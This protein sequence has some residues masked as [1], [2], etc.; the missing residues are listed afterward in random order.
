MA[1][2]STLDRRDGRRDDEPRPLQ[3]TLDFVKYPEGSVLA[4]AGDTVV[5][6]NVTVEGRVPP[7]LRDTGEGWLTSEYAM[8]PRATEERSPREST[9]GSIS[10]RSA[11]IQRLIGRS[12]R[13]SLDMGS[14]GERT[15]VVDCDVLQ[16]DGGTRT[17]AITG[18]FVAVVL[19]LLHLKEQKALPA[20]PVRDQLAAVSVG[21]VAG[22]PL[23]DLAYD[24]DSR[25]GVDLN[26]IATAR[27]GIVEVQG[28][29]EREPFSRRDLDR[30][31][32]LAETGLER[33]FAAQRSVLDHRLEKAGLKSL[34]A[35][36]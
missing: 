21:I 9:R 23:L 24:E 35:E 33:A 16:A 7:F 26:L 12:L 20:W 32:D 18:A 27:K 25:A 19:A 1:N 10:G 17:T 2:S 14:L 5:V 15:L 34:V 3:L 8:L 28:T 36:K 13:A 11:E 29:A 30:L 6:C 31:L 4:R 22:R